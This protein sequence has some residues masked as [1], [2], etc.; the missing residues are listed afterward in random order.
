MPFEKWLII[1]IKLK[2]FCK[3]KGI[4]LEVFDACCELCKK[5]F[6][7]NDLMGGFEGFATFDKEEY[8]LE[9]CEKLAHDFFNKRKIKISSITRG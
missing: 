2:D 3:K 4:Q 9:M 5:N 1:A 8:T 7:P 6:K